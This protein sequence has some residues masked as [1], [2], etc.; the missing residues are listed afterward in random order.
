MEHIKSDKS[1]QLIIIS[2]AGIL[3]A[4]FLFLFSVFIQSR[5]IVTIIQSINVVVFG[6]TIMLA[7]KGIAVKKLC[8]FIVCYQLF[9]LVGSWSSIDFTYHSTRILALYATLNI[10]I[11]LEGK[12]KKVMYSI[13]IFIISSMLALDILKL[14]GEKTVILEYIEVVSGSFIIGG[15]MIL[16]ASIFKRKYKTVHDEFYV[17]SI[18]DSLTDAYNIRYFHQLKAKADRQWKLETKP[19]SVGILDLDDFKK[20]NDTYGHYWGDKVLKETVKQIRDLLE[21]DRLIFRYGGDEFLILASVCNKEQLKE[22]MIR[23]VNKFNDKPVQLDDDKK[24]WVTLSIGV[25]DMYEVE[26]YN[27]HSDQEIDILGLA[28]KK[29]YLA[30]QEGKARVC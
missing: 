5:T 8:L 15:S 14:G 27:I 30:K 7:S 28:D 11:L 29:L 23:V 26:E 1:Q 3:G 20:I 6:I 19:Y 25:S 2:I 13:E 10:S 12:K 16:L 24:V 22:A 9:L 18:K 17:L 21:D 4:I